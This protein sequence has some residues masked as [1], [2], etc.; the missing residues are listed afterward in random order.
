M[1][2]DLT[3]V[4]FI[5]DRSGSMNGLEDDTIGGFNTMLEK[6]KSAPGEALISTV[7]FNQTSKVVHDRVSVQRVHK[8]TREDYCP[9]GCTALLDAL[10]DAISHIRTVHKYAREEDVPQRTL[11][12]ITTD[13][14]ENA[15]RRY[16]AGRVKAMIEAQK[17]AGW[18]FL[19]LGA[20]IDAVETASRMGISADCAVTY[21]SDEQGT[22]LNYESIDEAICAVRCSAPLTKAWKRSI[23]DDAEKRK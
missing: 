9:T 6:Q 13:G 22:R 7:L 5:L 21:F 11:F 4:V 8:L 3:E 10:G 14:M 20:N 15:S 18:D 19:F 1:K 17:S 16:D 12:V 23:E 2:K